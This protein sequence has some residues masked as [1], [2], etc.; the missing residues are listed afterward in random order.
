[1]QN[2]FGCPSNNARP[3][4]TETEHIRK[5]NTALLILFRVFLI[6]TLCQSLVVFLSNR[7]VLGHGLWLESSWVVSASWNASMHF[8]IHS[9]AAH[10]P[11][12]TS[13][14]EWSQKPK[15]NLSGSLSLLLKGGV[16]KNAR[17]HVCRMR[18]VWFLDS[19]GTSV[20]KGVLYLAGHLSSNATMQLE[21]KNL[22]LNLQI[23][24]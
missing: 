22:R 7:H 8:V 3:S 14:S 17:E 13:I 15:P 11:Q 1:M 5:A 19:L 10:A 24:Y 23:R 4:E 6:V 2:T 16:G 18:S 21:P 12:T 9:P 20:T